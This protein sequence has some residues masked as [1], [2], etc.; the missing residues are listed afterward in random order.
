MVEANGLELTEQEA[1]LYDRQIRL[2]GLDSQKRLRAARILLCGVNGL[3]AEIAKNIILSGVKSVTLLD[4]KNVSEE[5]FCSQ[6]F[7]P[8]SSIDKNRAE[9]SYQRAQNL[10]PMVEV[11]VDTEELSAKPNEYFHNFD[12]VCVT[13][14]A[15]SEL[16]RI[17][18][19]CRAAG[20][21]FFTSDLW[22][23]FG[24]SFADLQEH[25]FAE[26]VYKHKIISKPNE[27][28]KTELVSSTVKRT[29]NFHPYQ[30]VVDFDLKSAAYL[31]K[32]KRSGPALIVL[33]IL[34]KFRD[35][36]KRDPSYKH[37]E[38]DL[39]KLCAIRDELAEG[40]VPDDAFVHVFAQISPAAAIIGGE[41][42][43]EIIKTVSQKEA[44]HH[45]L[46]LFDPEKCCGFI[47][48]IGN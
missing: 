20:V 29:L 7:T 44:P 43:H 40:F 45:N 2:W 48:S 46:F 17:N 47:E 35:T 37:R 6:F 34:Q 38:E 4:N 26:D 16:V 12:V 39:Q 30:C 11:K 27:K 14:A 9:A 25:N 23:M 24:Y 22:G 19:T 1:E 32:V 5:D 42:A 21:K 41:V 10:N 15:T 33:R 31:K 36:E 8:Q 3:G 18:E 13:E 28:V